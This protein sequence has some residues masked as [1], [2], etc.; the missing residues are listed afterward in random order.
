MNI[1][2]LFVLL[3]DIKAGNDLFTSLI[4]E[5]RSH[6][7]NVFV[8]TKGNYT[9]KTKI[10]IEDD[11]PVL[12]IKSHNFIGVKN[13]VK[14]ALAYQE[15]SIK[16]AYY[17][18]HYFKD[19][20]IDLIIIHSL[21]P[22][23]SLI[24]WPL[25]RR[26][27]CPVFLIQTDYTWQDAVAFGFFSK[28]GLV[29]R[30]YRFLERK[31]FGLSDKIGCPTK[32][33]IGF[34]KKEYPNLS[35]KKF[36]FLPLWQSE[37]E[38]HPNY[39]LKEAYGLKDKFVVIYGGSIGFAQRIERIIE[40]AEQC[41]EYIDIKFV[42]LGRGE[43]VPDINNII[44]E[45]KLSNIVI[46][47][48]LPQNEYLQ[49]LASCDVGLVFLNEKIATPNFPSKSLSYLN[50][51]VP[52]LAALDHVTD[53]GTYLE[54]NNAGLWGYSDDILSL[55]TQLLKYYNSKELRNI[56]KDNGYK[57]F[58]DQLTPDKAYKTITTSL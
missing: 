7:H 49:F 33:N 5:F 44:K 27:K 55:K 13:N 16:Q 8:S 48:Y 53:F 31:M 32:G 29:A 37:M 15:Y 17:T 42:V 54:E 56:I 23:I 1:L 14:K 51:K 9:S 26:N 41:K 36:Q 57:L 18:Y 11:I 43:H 45:K 47:Q 12:R 6:G 52:I 4:K 21:P 19:E 38:I 35:D 25:K 50:M 22:E 40:L 46:K 2:F 10:I 20:N 3:P 28:N 30:Y 58:K 39:A 24:V 34:I